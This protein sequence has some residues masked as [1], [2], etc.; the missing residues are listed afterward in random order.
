MCTAYGW[1]GERSENGDGKDGN[2]I[3]G[4]GKRVKIE[5]ALVWR[6]LGLVW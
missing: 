2:K 5:R 3:S 4:G 1:I 6:R